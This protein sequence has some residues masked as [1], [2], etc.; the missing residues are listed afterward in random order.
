MAKV[1]GKGTDKKS[2]EDHFHHLSS[3]EIGAVL[4]RRRKQL[5]RTQKE[6]AAL[7]GGVAV[8]TV[9]QIESGERRPSL[10]LWL[11]AVPKGYSVKNP[12]DL[13]R[14]NN[15]VEKQAVVIKRS[16]LLE[17]IDFEGGLLYSMSKE[18]VE[19]EQ[20][21]AS[22]VTLDGNGESEETHHPSEEI[23][24][25]LEGD[26]I[27][28]IHNDHD[29]EW[30]L[31]SGDMVHFKSDHPHQIKNTKPTPAKMLIIRHPAR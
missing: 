29:E 17:Q 19:E 12:N 9:S 10:R 4:R 3:E 5:G 6:V 23:I 8:S 11:E 2:P 22:I 16:T 13:L 18:R 31:T 28:S 26:I 24:Y 14:Q 21:F 1:H 27:F 25:I 7:L 15:I 30:T 20:I